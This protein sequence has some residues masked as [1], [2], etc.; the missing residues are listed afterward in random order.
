MRKQLAN[1][2][3]LIQEKN[4]TI[5]NL[6]N[7]VASSTEKLK[8]TQN[9]VDE[10]RSQLEKTDDTREKLSKELKQTQDALIHLQR[11]TSVSGRHWSIGTTCGLNSSSAAPF[12]NGVLAGLGRG[13]ESL[14]VYKE[15]HKNGSN[16]VRNFRYV[17]PHGSDGI[18]SPM[19]KA[20][21]TTANGVLDSRENDKK[22]DFGHSGLEEHS[23][24]N[25][26][27]KKSSNDRANGASSNTTLITGGSGSAVSSERNKFDDKLVNG[28]SSK[29]NM[30]L[31][32][33]SAATTST[34]QL[35]PAKNF[36]ASDHQ[37]AA[38]SENA[39]TQHSKGLDRVA[40]GMIT[41][42]YF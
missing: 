10:L 3:K 19:P 13:S 24:Q 36:F 11:S 39:S 35:F 22:V 37:T 14:D 15:L 12:T 42:A 8:S 18:S 21:S 32:E 40:V 4:N 7:E 17:S 5:T 34:V 16:A 33:A 28:Q 41:S 38:L 30:N 29:R 23:H 6:R 25:E 26:P 31:M 9:K 27:S 1:Q 2:E 20:F